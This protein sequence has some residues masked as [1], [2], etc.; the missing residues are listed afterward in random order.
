MED[1]IQLLSIAIDVQMLEQ[2]TSKAKF[3]NTDL[4]YLIR[5]FIIKFVEN[6]DI[7]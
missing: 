2:A 4:E 5:L 1:K 7:I 6:D 3:L